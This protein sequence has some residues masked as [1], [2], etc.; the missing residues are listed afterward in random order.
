[1]RPALKLIV[2]ALPL[3]ALGA[4]FLAYAVANRPE[5]ARIDIA[6]RAVPVRFVEV[7]PASLPPRVIGNGLVRPARVFEAVAE[8]GGTVEWLDPGLE[9]GSIL[10]EGKVFLRLSK[11]DYSL[12]VAQAEANVR[13]TEAKLEEL[14]LSES[15]Q[16][17]ALELERKLLEIRTADRD[18]IARLVERGAAS[19]TALDAARAAWLA[20][21]QKVLTLENAIS[22][23]PTQRQVLVEQINVYKAALEAARL[24]LER[25]ELTLPFTARVAKEEV[26]IGQFVRQGQ[27][28]AIFDGIDAAEV[29]VRIS[30]SEM[31]ALTSPSAEGDHLLDPVRLGEQLRAMGLRAEVRL[32][33]G[34]R[35][36]I[37]PAQ[38]DRLSD[39]VDQKTG[40]L[41]VIL[42]VDNA[43]SSARPGLRPPLTKGMFVE[44]VLSAP[45]RSGIIVPRSAVHEGRVMIADDENRLRLLPVTILRA[46]DQVALIGEGLEAGMRLIVSDLSP[47]IPGQLLAPVR[48]EALEKRL[49]AQS[50]GGMAERR[51]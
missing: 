9:T 10:P 18:R 46:Q 25:T 11:A 6:E 20:Q 31:S 22:L 4:G 14:E 15:N 35:Q 30:L 21:R 16:K 47:R 19:A 8:V 48:D 43:Y 23:I 32:E 28:V 34:G 42:R 2:I 38:V 5:P 3:A 51:K 27:L 45:G 49:A 29:E 50:A 26:E 33:L 17:A 41:G 44:A 40:T 24:N 7:T 12:A 39:T 13:A 37:W 1:M 36:L